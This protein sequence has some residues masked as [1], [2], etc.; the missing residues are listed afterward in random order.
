MLTLNI[1]ISEI[2]DPPV[3]PELAGKIKVGS[4]HSVTIME[5][6][7]QSGATSLYFLVNTPNG[8]VAV[9]TSGALLEGLHSAL[10]GANQRF[11]EKKNY[12]KN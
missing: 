12:G 6:G 3:F 4:F 2:G 11:K 1:K 7:M 5:G 9:E 10:Q 8:I